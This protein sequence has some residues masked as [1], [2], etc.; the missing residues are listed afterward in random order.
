MTNVWKPKWKAKVR[1]RFMHG[2]AAT[3]FYLFLCNV[4]FFHLKFSLLLLSLMLWNFFFLVTDASGKFFHICEWSLIYTSIRIG[5]H[6]WKQCRGPTLFYRT[7]SDE[8]KV[9]WNFNLRLFK[10]WLFLLLLFFDVLL[11]FF[12]IKLNRFLQR[13]RF[14]FQKNLLPRFSELGQVV[15]LLQ[16]L[17]GFPALFPFLFSGVKVT[18]LIFFVADFLPN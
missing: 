16:K 2:L 7:V 10:L 1:F 4:G 9:L 12:F 14:R 13:L 5:W 17:D 11:L 6:D 18:K 15:F 3:S 8:K